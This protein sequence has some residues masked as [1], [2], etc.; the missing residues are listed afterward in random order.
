MRWRILILL[1]FFIGIDYRGSSQPGSIAQKET[2]CAGL[3]SKILDLHYSDPDSA[4]IYSDKFEKEFKRLITTQP[5]T[6]DYPFSRLTDS[7]YCLIRTSPDKRLKIYSWDTWLGGSMHEYRTIYQWRQ[8]G[9]VNAKMRP[10]NGDIGSY[11]SKIYNVLIAGKTYYL[12]ITNAI[13]SNKDH[14]QTITAYTINGNQLE[15]KAAIF[16]TNGKALSIISINFDFFSVVDS[17]GRPLE[18]I[19]YNEAK[20]QLYIPFVGKNDQVTRRRFVYQLTD[21]GFEYAG[22]Q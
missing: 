14:S 6:F 21:K 3:Y 7:N 16:H 19:V 8:D 5:G 10:I 1:M 12:V 18:L 2:Y 20:H 17:P 15:D 22:M 11:C 4:A 9:T 13:F